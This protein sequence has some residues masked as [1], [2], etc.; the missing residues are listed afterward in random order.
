MRSLESL[1]HNIAGLI[2]G[3]YRAQFRPVITS[4]DKPNRIKS[5]E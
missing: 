4:I 3:S 5:N 1:T 2:D